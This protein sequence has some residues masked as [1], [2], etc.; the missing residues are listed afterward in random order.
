MRKRL[1]TFIAACFY[2]SGL[3]NLARW[4]M[5]HSGRHLVIL[6]YHRATGGDLLSH[7]RYL[8]RHYRILP[9]QAALEELYIHTEHGNRRGLSGA[10]A[11][12][13]R[14]R[15]GARINSLLPT[16]STELAE[17]VSIPSAPQKRI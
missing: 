6:N 11:S 7:L 17:R 8:Q 1:L 12:G 10:A 4:L 3:V 16:A 5:R 14:S 13:G 2:Y 15:R 9:L